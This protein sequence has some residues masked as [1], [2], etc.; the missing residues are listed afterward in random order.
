MNLVKTSFWSGLSSV[1]K[2]LSGLVITKIIAMVVGPNG[3]A[4]LGNFTN[5]TGMFTTF[6]NGGISSGVTKYIAEFDNEEEK[7]HV[8]S[9]AVKVNLICSFIIGLGIIIFNKAL[10]QLAFGNTENRIAFILFGIT[11]VFYGMNTTI[12]AVLNGYKYIKYLI[13]IGMIG[14]AVSV[15]LAMA[16]TIPFGLFGALINTMIAQVVIFLFSTII[17]RKLKIFRIRLLYSKF[18]RS[19]LWKLFKYATMSL[20]TA[21]SVPTGTFLIRNYIY[22]NF[23]PNE[24]GYVQGVWSISSAYLMVVTTT[25]SIYYLPTL[26]SIKDRLGIRREIIKGYKFLLPIAVAGGIAIYI[27]RDLIIHI[28]YTPTFLPMKEY[29]IFQ[30]IGDTFKIASW[31]LAYIMVAKAMTRWFIVSEVVFSCTYVGFSFL[32]MRWFGSTGVTYAYAL[33]YFIYLVF[34]VVLFREYLFVKKTTMSI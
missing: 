27:C 3:V 26:S 22:K 16:I 33:N 2:I 15:I 21:L 30:I 18:N 13:I 14:S 6:A 20:V 31:I 7:R 4:L 32:F 24:A 28:L 5:I 10:T 9:H 25:L 23:S 17:I 1:F 8:V 11:V 12:S 34:M 29:F 19:L